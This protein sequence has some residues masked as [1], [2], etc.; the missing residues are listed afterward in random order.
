MGFNLEGNKNNEIKEMPEVKVDSEQL[1]ETEETAEN[2]D[3]CSLNEVQDSKG[4]KVN[5]ESLEEA[6]ENYDDCEAKMEEMEE[7]NPELVD[8]DDDFN[9]CGKETEGQYVAEVTYTTD[10]EVSEEEASVELQEA[11]NECDN[12]EDMQQLK[13]NAN[14]NEHIEVHNAEVVERPENTEMDSEVTEEEYEHAKEELEEA[15]ENLEAQQDAAQE[16]QEDLE[17]QINSHGNE[18]PNEGTEN[19]DNQESEEG[20]ETEEV[21]ENSETEEIEEDSESDEVEGNSE[22]ANS[23][24][25]ES[26]NAKFDGLE[27]MNDDSNVEVSNIDEENISKSI[28]QEAEDEIGAKIGEE[29]QNEIKNEDSDEINAEAEDGKIS[30]AEAEEIVNSKVF[31]KAESVKDEAEAVNGEIENCAEEVAENDDLASDEATEQISDEVTDS[32][33]ENLSEED[34]KEMV[35]EKADAIEDAVDEK[36][37]EKENSEAVEETTE[38]L[39]TEQ[40]EQTFGRTQLSLQERIDGAFE[41]EDVSTDEINKLRDENVAELK[42]KIEE[43]GLA[44]SELKSK[45]DEVLSKAKGSEEYKQSLREYNAL[46]DKKIVIDEQIAS[47]EEQQDLLDKKSLE[48]REAQIQKGTEAVVASTATLSDAS[49]IQKR[50]DHAFYGAKY[51]TADLASIREDSCSV[52]KELAEEKESI[53]QALDAKMTEISEYVISNNMDRYDTAHDAN[54]QKLSAEYVAMKENYDRVGYSIV[55]L[56]ENNKTITE[57]LGDEYVSMVELPPSSRIAEINNGTDIPG[58]TNYFIDEAKASEVLAPF[59]QERW[60]RLTV[61]EQ[62]QAVDK[63]ADYNAEILGVEDKPRIVYYSAE[64]PSDFGGYSAKLNAIYINE[65]NMHD[66]TETAD[67]I[68]HEYRHKYQHER[69]EKLET[70]RDLEFK[71]SFDNYIRAEDDYQGYK[72]QLVEADARD[73]AQVIQDKINE[74]DSECADNAVSVAATEGTVPSYSELNPEKGA[75]WDKPSQ[76]KV[77]F[78]PEHIEV[79]YKG[80]LTNDGERI[81]YEEAVGRITSNAEKYMVLMGIDKGVRD[82]V[83]EDMRSK[84]YKQQLESESRGLGDHGIRHIYGNYERGE[85]YLATRNDISEEQKLAVLVSQV[86]HDEGYTIAPNN[87]GTLIEGNSD[88]KHDEASLTEWDKSKNL[89]NFFHPETMDSI[90]KAI[91]EH[92]VGAKDK[93]RENKNGIALKIDT[94]NGGREE[95]FIDGIDRI[96]ENTSIESDV[97]VSTVHICDKLALSQ[98]EKFSEL[99]S[100]DSKLVE[101]TGGMNMS[102]KILQDERLGFYVN[103]EL[104]SHGK[105]I[106]DNYHQAIYEY[107]DGKGFSPEYAQRLKDAVNKD[108]GFNAGK[109]SSRM[110]YIYTPSDCYQYSPETGRNEITVYVIHH[111]DGSP[112]DLAYKQVEKMYEDLGLYEKEIQIAKANG[113]YD[114]GR[115]R[116]LSVKVESITEEE[117]KRLESEKFQENNDLK[118]INEC[119]EFG[120]RDYKEFSQALA[121]IAMIKDDGDISLDVYSKIASKGNIVVEFTEDE[122]ATLSD[123]KKEELVKEAVSGMIL[124]RATQTLNK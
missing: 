111:T 66:A 56:D 103:G 40:A 101:L 110:N 51:D 104:T 57:L 98:R 106:L 65:Y 102:L 72:K 78:M 36:K 90:E 94:Q 77:K 61:Q 15:Q 24:Q 14:E 8:D 83:L 22:T 108:V 85:K 30:V 46:Q 119:I 75:V 109:F 52:I 120:R 11:Y 81:T 2:F 100:S 39:E 99:L 112:N 88:K 54:Y 23:E 9:D 41:K 1:S 82:K 74:T 5:S 91:G 79:E 114:F 121:K 20:A 115:E 29:S 35:D 19:I 63:L 64:D 113:G 59:K 84:L 71:E 69:A 70:E 26:E 27:Q 93:L 3:D 44:E 33:S 49:V 17:N 105:R 45:F 122:F 76:L 47:M 6:E 96:K 80:F 25:V 42:A 34:A 12:P 89:Y 107:I 60:E 13:E 31:E 87:L 16:Y 18:I 117:I 21:E 37:E 67:T 73:Y 86:Y 95:K 68:S 28:S 7:Q 50:Y 55:K 38:E 124:L 116:G 58:E 92:N 118:E 32:A 10:G 53:R 43:K 123:S 97:I 48:L 62:K 4:N